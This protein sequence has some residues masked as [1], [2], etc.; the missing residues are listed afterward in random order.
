MKQFTI[1][2]LKQTVDACLGS[3]TAT[4]LDG[5]VIDERFDELGYDSLAVYEFVTRLQDELSIAISDDDVDTLKTPRAV[6]DF[7]NGRL[8]EVAG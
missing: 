5:K 6:I 1:D 7:V 4:L 2:D 8:A 3:E